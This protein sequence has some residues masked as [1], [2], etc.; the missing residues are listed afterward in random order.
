M[1]PR[2]GSGRQPRTYSLTDLGRLV[3]AVPSL[4]ASHFRVLALRD[5][6]A[7]THGTR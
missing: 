1:T 6:T 5:G 7:V 3:L 4:P 2:I